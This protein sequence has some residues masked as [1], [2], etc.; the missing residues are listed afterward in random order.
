MDGAFIGAKWMGTF[1]R[2]QY[3]NDYKNV[4]FSFGKGS[5]N[6]FLADGTRSYLGPVQRQE[7]LRPACRSINHIMSNT[8]DEQYYLIFDKMNSSIL[9]HYFYNFQ[10]FVQCGAGFN[11]DYENNY[12]FNYALAK[13]WDVVIHFNETRES[14][15]R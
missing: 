10:P 12:K 14:Q 5:F 1:L 2:E 6:A 13:M 9:N 4:M 8:E 7:I 11:Y 3:G 15:L